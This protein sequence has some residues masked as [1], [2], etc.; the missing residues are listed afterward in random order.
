NANS[1]RL[2]NAAGYDVV[3][4]PAQ[5]CCGALYAHSGN[6]ARAC[7]CARANIAAFEGSGCEV[8]IT[9]AAGCGSSLKEYGN[10]LK[11]EAA[12]QFG[13]S[14]KDLTEFLA[15]RPL[16]PL[17]TSGE[18]VTYH[19]ACHLAHAQRIAQAPRDLVRTVAG[20]NFVE[21]PEAD[22]CCG[23]AGTYNLTEP[24]M[25]ERLQRRK[26]ENI[27]KTNAEIVVTS[28]PGCILQIQ[29][30][31]NKAGSRIR[32]MHIADYLCGSIQPPP[33]TKSSS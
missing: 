24:E 28:N 6:L 31:L 7:D 29:A 15:G 13:A 25:A 20:E 23:S 33:T 16:P 10:W 22:V 27:L 18:R 3:T 12:A 9:N 17:K 5:G 21:L 8:I 30:G 11:S 19:D 2:L 4:P 14:V 32:V 1:V 26:I